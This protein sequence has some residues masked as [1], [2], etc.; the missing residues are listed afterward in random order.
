[1]AKK[2]STE[3]PEPGALIAENLRRASRQ[4]APII[5]DWLC[6]PEINRYLSSNLRDCG[7]EPG[8]ANAALRRPDQLWSIFSSDDGNPVGLIALDSI[9]LVDGVANIWYLLGRSD[10]AG[11]GL[12]SAAIER[13][14][15]ANPAGLHTLIA[16]VGE[17]NTASLRCLEKASFHVIGRIAGGFVFEDARYDRILYER[18]LTVAE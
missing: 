1:M 12:T 9:D 2:R 15:A 3:T 5:A 11:R 17:P 14:C 7:L 4:D 16:W 8:L 18:V 6:Q 13:F 10:A